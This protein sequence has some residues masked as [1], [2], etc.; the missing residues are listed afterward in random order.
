MGSKLY[1]LKPLTFWRTVPYVSFGKMPLPLI[2]N[3][4][5][6]AL[7]NKSNPTWGDFVGIRQPL[8]DHVCY[9]APRIGPL[10]YHTSRF[11][12]LYHTSRFP[13]LLSHLSSAL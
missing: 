7:L 8:H 11:R 2:S 3:M 4:L 13:F 6:V 5:F 10:L 9:S 1:Y 12:L